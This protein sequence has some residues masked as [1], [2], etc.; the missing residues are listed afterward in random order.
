MRRGR[1]IL[2]TTAALLLG[3]LPLVAGHGEDGSASVAVPLSDPND[4]YQEHGANYFGHGH[5]TGWILA[6]IILMSAAWIFTMPLAIM[7]SVARSRY[8]LP[9]QVLFHALN[10]AGVFTGFVYNHATPDLYEH[11]AHHPIGWIVTSSTIIWTIASLYTAYGDYRSRH[12]GQGHP[13]SSNDTAYYSVLQQYSDRAELARW[14][15][16]SGVGSSRQH[17][18]ES[19]PQKPEEPESPVHD[20]LGD[21]KPD[22]EDSDE[23]EP[24]KRG[25]LGNNRVDRF[26]S[27]YAQRLS[28]PR[29]S[30]VVRCSQIILEK[31]L[32]L[33]GFFALCTGFVTYGGLGRA[34]QVFSLAAH[35]VKG[36]IF[37]WYGVLTLGRWMGAFTEFGWAWNVRPDYPLVAR[38]KTRVPSA[39]FVESFVIWLYGASNVF[40]EH[41]NSWG[42]EWHPQDFEHVSLTVL[43]FGGGLLGM[44]VDSAWFRT[45]MNTSVVLQSS[46]LA[47]ASRFA[48]D[49]VEA[50]AADVPDDHWQEPKTYQ[51]P[52][53]PM[54][55][56]VIMILGIMMSAH[57]QH[58]MV[59]T[60]M[61]TQ[62]GTL[63]FAFAIARATTYL[64][65]FLKPPTSH[66]P[67]RPPSEL[68]TA[69]CL[70]S[71]GL[72]FMV[73]AHDTIWAIETSGLDAMTIFTVTMGLTGIVM[74]WEVVC[75]AV[76]GWAV[77]K[78]RAA[79]GQPL[80]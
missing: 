58:S 34:N 38:W 71:G 3:A 42:G 66:F 74:A 2:S 37:V 61:H 26:V 6:H 29:A 25:F 79:A 36:G 4:H 52:L 68:V 51:V 72:L 49:G 44:L 20:D 16:D 5:Y 24:R 21:D 14:S 62:W 76:K 12:G 80:P 41:L 39:E 33:L 11:N 47:D 43:F 7:L 53:N 8:H 48:A 73:S 64:I 55:G 32:L 46:R 10:G 1:I 45:Q 35:F 65:L 63:F 9:A 77:R 31:I 22:G 19:I 13:L 27:H 15:V 70:M 18:S 54:P 75:F 57:H 23:D 78:E 17:R 56:L 69:F 40:L 30:T 28:T 60:M 67:A 50:G 59:S